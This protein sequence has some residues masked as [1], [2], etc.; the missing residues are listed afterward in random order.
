MLLNIHSYTSYNQL[1]L[2][3]EVTSDFLPVYSY[4]IFMLQNI[5]KTRGSN[6]TQ[7]YYKQSLLYQSLFFFLSLV[8][9]NTNKRSLSR[10]QEIR[11]PKDFP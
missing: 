1:Y 6:I 11:R 4:I 9:N 7:L 3:K 8:D 10:Q 5:H 2:W